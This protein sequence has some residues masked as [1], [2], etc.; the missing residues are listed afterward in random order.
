MRYY[1]LALTILAAPLGAQQSDSTNTITLQVSG[2]LD[3]VYNRVLEVAGANGLAT[4]YAVQPYAIHL[5]P[6][7]NPNQTIRISISGEANKALIQLSSVFYEESHGMSYS[8][9]KTV[10]VDKET[11]KG[12]AWIRLQRLAELLR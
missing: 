10:P 2:G 3:R 11:D 4:V 1:L 6:V 12:R 7:G 8:F 5:Q 9:G